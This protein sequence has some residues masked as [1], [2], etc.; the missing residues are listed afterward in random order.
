MNKTIKQTCA[1]LARLLAAVGIAMFFCCWL[2]NALDWLRNFGIPSLPSSLAQAPLVQHHPLPAR[3]MPLAQM[4]AVYNSAF[5]GYG[6]FGSGLG[7]VIAAIWAF[8]RCRSYTFSARL[9]VGFVAGFITGARLFMTVSSD[10][11]L[12]LAFG[13]LGAVLFQLNVCL[14]EQ[15]PAFQPLPRLRL[16]GAGGDEAATQL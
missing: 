1:G 15:P 9:L 13:A 11:V 4:L 10:A 12:V 14:S 6:R 3:L 5:P 8:Q 7:M 16:H 2:F